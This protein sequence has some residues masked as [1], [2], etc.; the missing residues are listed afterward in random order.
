MR[1]AIDLQPL[2][3]ATSRNRG[4]GR[5]V[6]AVLERILDRQPGNTEYRLYANARLPEPEL[7]ERHTSLVRRIT[8]PQEGI[9]EVNSVFFST[10]LL[11][12]RVDA[13][14]M[15]SPIE[16]VDAVVPDFS[17]FPAILYTICYDLIP[18]L[19]PEKYLENTALRIL[20][21]KRLKNIQASDF[22]FCISESTRDD[23]VDRLK[24]RPESVVNVS[25]GVSPFFKPTP[26]GEK[27]VWREELK[28]KFSIKKP[29]V[30]Y[31]GGED[32]RKNMEGLVTAFAALPA[33]LR[34]DYQLVLACKISDE[35]LHRLKELARREGLDHRQSL[36]LTNYVSDEELRALYGLC[37]LFVFPS[38]YEGFGLPLVEAM[39]CGAPVVAGNNSSLREIVTEPDQLFDPASAPSMAFRMEALLRD[40]AHRAILIEQGPQR[41]VS[42]SWDAVASRIADCLE[43][44]RPP[45]AE[46]ITFSRGK[47]LE[48]VPRFRDAITRVTK[49]PERGLDISSVLPPSKEGRPR[50]A[51]FSPFRPQQSGI[52]DY[53]EEILPAL[54]EHYQI[55]LYIDDG[56]TPLLERSLYHRVYNHQ[57]F[58]HN[59]TWRNL[60]YESVVH[61]MGNSAFHVYQYACLLR[62]A[63]ITV[64]HDYNIS[65][66]VNY[67]SNRRPDVGITLEGE[68]IHQYGADKAKEI[69]RPL[70]KGESAVEDLPG[71][72]VYTNKRVF[73][74]SLGVIVH[75][76][77][78]YNK[79]LQ[80]HGHHNEMIALIPPVMPPVPL[81]ITQ[82]ER[83]QLRRKLHIPEDAFVFASCGTVAQTKRPLQ[84][85][86]ALKIYLSR[87]PNAFLIFVGYLNRQEI[88]LDAEIQKR[89]LE[90]NVAV[91]GPVEMPVFNEYLIASDVCVTLRYPSNGE[92]SGALLRMMAH[93]KPSIVTDIGSFGNFPDRAV[94]KLPTP[95]KGDEVANI[96]EAFEV[97]ATNHE[98]R[99]ALGRAA[100]AYIHQEHSP[101]RCARLYADFISQVMQHPHTRPKLLA[102]YVARGVAASPNTENT[103]NKVTLFMPFVEL[104]RR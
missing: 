23:V 88:N 73:T 18:L 46:T 64:L 102:D 98:Y 2:Q 49:I 26:E 92:S 14:F 40:P 6:Q 32:W 95:D 12:D 5:Y 74:R 87:H 39:A 35:G 56:Y 21:M 4:I 50:L 71:M 100:V 94:H 60:N 57:S 20:Y 76:Q 13:I 91:S 68:L 52:S 22:V 16:F 41:A 77:W 63:G 29:F 104:L 36:V 33:S 27:A 38:F 96:T 61:Q 78:S 17:N 89:G 67:I 51:F 75:N 3:S 80:D 90:K 58:D 54:G 48:K 72:G 53:S 59:V 62:Y 66:L 8:F 19:F 42:F 24:L 65:G 10:V 101:E 86:D 82:A 79:A 7:P 81:D 31:T 84:L 34:A 28:R 45:R 83:L 55:D 69:L 9:G 97:L 103:E 25:G 11:A 99:E 15:P 43:A 47:S 30:L 93:G 85:L 70:D 1:V 37:D 44:P